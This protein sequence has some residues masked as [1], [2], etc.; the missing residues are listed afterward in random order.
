VRNRAVWGAATFLAAGVLAIVVGVA[1][2]AAGVTTPSS[3]ITTAG[4]SAVMPEFS[5]TVADSF[6]TMDGALFR[7]SDAWHI[8]PTALQPTQVPWSGP[9]TCGI[10]SMTDGNGQVITSAQPVDCFFRFSVAGFYL[11]RLVTENTSVPSPITVTFTAGALTAPSLGTS[12]TWTVASV[13]NTDGSTPASLV[14]NL[15]DLAVT[16]EAQYISCEQGQPMESAPLAPTGF[17]GTVSYD[18]LDDVPPGLVFDP[19]TG[20]IS[21]TPTVAVVPT[22]VRIEVT[23]STTAGSATG[24]VGLNVTDPSTTTVPTSSTTAPVTPTTVPPQGPA[25]AKSGGDLRPAL[26]AGGLL[27]LVGAALL[28]PA[29]RT[30]RH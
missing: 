11:L 1:P 5:V 27:V 4:H 10:A 19:A 8:A 29:R 15:V 22:T 12:S 20:V 18:L 28:I 25:L 26:A 23:S 16:P 9:G 30:L 14:F 21:G 17:T 13:N 24:T 2:A 3:S 6:G 7:I